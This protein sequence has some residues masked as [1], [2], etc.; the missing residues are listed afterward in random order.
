MTGWPWINMISSAEFIDL[1]V[2]ALPPDASQREQD[3]LREALQRLVNVVQLEQ[4]QAIQTDFDTVD[5]L[6]SSYRRS[7]DED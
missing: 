4:V 2:G 6:M 7:A 3:I 1:I 5:N